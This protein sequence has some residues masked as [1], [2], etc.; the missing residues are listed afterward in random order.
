MLVRSKL[1]LRVITY[2]IYTLKIA[3]RTNVF[4]TVLFINYSQ[5]LLSVLLLK[6][7]VDQFHGTGSFL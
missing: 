3:Y 7:S 5:S 4:A 1:I 6:Q 2:V